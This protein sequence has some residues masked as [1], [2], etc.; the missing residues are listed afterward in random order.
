MQAIT[1]TTATTGYNPE[2]G[3]P[4]GF[5]GLRYVA[6]VLRGELGFSSPDLTAAGL[7]AA[8][9]AFARKGICVRAMR[10]RHGYYFTIGIK[11]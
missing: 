10:W 1:A 6:R 4:L 9:A 2:T 7:E 3:F 8:R 5:G 11:N